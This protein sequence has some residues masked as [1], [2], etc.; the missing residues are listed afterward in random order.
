MFYNWIRKTGYWTL[1]ALKG[2]PIKNRYQHLKSV[3]EGNQDD[4][5]LKL[6]EHAIK[7]VP[8]YSSIPKP[9]LN[10]FPVVNKDTYRKAYDN[11]RSSA[12]PD[13]SQLH[14]IYTSGSTGTP[15]KAIQN[16]D[17]L[18][19]HQAGLI[20][21]NESIGWNLG[22]RFIF[23]RVWGMGH[24]AGWLSRTM[25]NMVPV[26]VIGFN[27]EE[28][29]RVRRIVLNDKKLDIIFGYSST[30][31]KLAETALTSKEKPQDYGL[32]L[33]I[34]DSE[35]LTKEARGKIEKAFQCPVYNRYGNN[36]NGILALAGSDDVFVVNYPEYFVEILKLDSDEQ[37]KY[38]ELGRVVITDLYNYAFPFIRYDT[39]DL[40]IAGQMKNDQCIELLELSG[41]VSSTLRDVKGG[42]VTETTVAAFFKTIPNVKRYQVVQE[43]VNEYIVNVEG[44]DMLDDNAINS[45][46]Y[47]CFGDEAIIKINRVSQIQPGKNGKYSTTIYKIKK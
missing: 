38:G 23:M 20:A 1:D 45:K 6:L 12:F 25:T 41:R 36:E 40:A 27:E 17:K 14:S 42:I 16:K 46:M 24:D 28:S 30:L 32:K 44:T 22:D 5:L 15:F 13:E 43:G 33:I 9:S 3:R 18:L 2:S 4:S 21:L 11:F 37:V 47:E 8:A 29:Q 19:W 7:T 35:Q 10:L 34:A 26:N 39:G 31:E